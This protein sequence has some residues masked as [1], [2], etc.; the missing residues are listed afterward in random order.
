MEREGK[1]LQLTRL[2]EVRL[3]RLHRLGRSG[4]REGHSGHGI[5]LFADFKPKAVG[6]HQGCRCNGR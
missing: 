5:A 2:E 3:R 4:H 1:G 6:F